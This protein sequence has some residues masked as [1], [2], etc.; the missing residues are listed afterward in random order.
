MANLE[1]FCDLLFEISNED[2][3]RIME[4]L[5]SEPLHA[6][7]VSRRLDILTQEA[8]R[9]LTRLA[10]VGLIAKG[11][12]GLY[13]LTPYGSLSLRLL[14]G[15][16]FV[17]RHREYFAGHTAAAIPRCF[18]SRIG[19]LGGAALVDDVMITM[20]N[21]ERVI[22]E[23]KEYVVRMTDR[24][25]LTAIPHIVGA[26]ER[27]VEFRAIEP[28]DIVRPPGYE[29]DPR[30]TRAEADGGWRDRAVERLGVCLTASEGE[31]A[32]LCFPAPDGRFDYCGFTSKDPDTHDWCMDLFEH[33][34][35]SGRGIRPD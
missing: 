18:T 7:G 17:S 16:R 34:W 25:Q 14:E 35:D 4:E 29:P 28:L 20:H 23:A 1:R 26:L 13:T 3:L 22:R 6:T 27:G 15:E 8:S 31:V 11:P 33:Y 19:E 9:H 24:Y 5:G 21:V 32:A 10:E 2:R 30:L 12:D